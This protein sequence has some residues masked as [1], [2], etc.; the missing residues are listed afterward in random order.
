MLLK[1]FEYI[2]FL[3]IIFDC[4]SIL[5]AAPHLKHRIQDEAQSLESLNLGIS[6]Q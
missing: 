6:G 5:N 4:W 3:T 1:S 2:N